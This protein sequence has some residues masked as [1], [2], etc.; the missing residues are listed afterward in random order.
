MSFTKA[1]RNQLCTEFHQ[2][3]QKGA[4]I[5]EKVDAGEGDADVLGARL[6]GVDTRLE[7]LRKTYLAGL[8]RLAISRCP[9]CGQPLTVAID[10]LG[11]DG[12]WWIAEAPVRPWFERTGACEHFRQLSGAM[13]LREPLEPCPRMVEA[14]PDV[15][16]VIKALMAHPGVHCV[17]SVMTIG[18]HA[19][20]PICYF[21]AAPFEDLTLFDA[22]G[23]DFNILPGTPESGDRSDVIERPVSPRLDMDRDLATCA[24]TTGRLHWIAPGDTAL[25]LRQDWGESPF[26]SISGTGK[27]QH[28]LSE[29]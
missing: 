7:E 28:I 10:N 18:Q 23:A 20:M 3:W 27:M 17:I 19:G 9:I 29:D 26:L 1:E 24:A 4:D 13:I 2:L 5:R 6:A 25:G 8:P 14:G 16:F 15:P 22:W 21:S 12:L 11:L